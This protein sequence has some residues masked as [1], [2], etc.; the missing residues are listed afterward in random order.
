METIQKRKIKKDHDFVNCKLKLTNTKPFSLGRQ[1]IVDPSQAN[2]V[3]CSWDHSYLLR[4]CCEW[5]LFGVVVTCKLYQL[6][7]TICLFV[8]V[9]SSEPKIGQNSDRIPHLLI[10]S[11]LKVWVSPGASAYRAN[12]HPRGPSQC[13]WGRRRFELAA[14]HSAD[15]PFA[16]TDHLKTTRRRKV[17]HLFCARNKNSQTPKTS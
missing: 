14:R 3:G 9:W 13:S 4:Q 15:L 6:C 8:R 7:P 5:N 10:S 16:P 17:K 1:D 2:R 12:V 11:S